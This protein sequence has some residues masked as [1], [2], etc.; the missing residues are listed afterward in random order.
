MTRPKQKYRRN[1]SKIWND[2]NGEIPYGYEVHHKLPKHMGGEDVLEN[3]EIVTSDQHKAR[4]LALYEEHNNFRDLCAYH[5]I[6]YNFTEAHKISSS[7]G[8]NIGGAKVYE[9]KIGIFR[10]DEDR[11]VWAA[12]AGKIGGT[13]QR[14]MK[15]GI[16]GLTPEQ[17]KEN[18]SK[19]GKNGGF[20]Q[21]HIQSANGKK[22]GP[23]N[24]G[25]RWYSD[26]I[27]NF[28]YTSGQQLV[29]SFDDFLQQHKA[30]RKGRK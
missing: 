15:L 25:F 5:M 18:A 23:K 10:S 19:G 9:E 28:K 11:R 14:D 4:H 13:K 21:S 6:G 29:L 26:G 27:N 20:T 1:C 30:Y 17:Q 8:G 7:N 12:Y 2:A 3:L 16:H 22:G 24:K